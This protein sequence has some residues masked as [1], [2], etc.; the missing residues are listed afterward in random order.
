MED[1]EDGRLRVGLGERI[2]GPAELQNRG[3]DF[4]KE[5][6]EPELRGQNSGVRESNKVT[7][8]YGL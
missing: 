6:L 7:Q 1:R 5:G 3:F 2:S 4:L 8:I